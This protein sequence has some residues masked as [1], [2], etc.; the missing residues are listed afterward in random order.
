MK[1]GVIQLDDSVECWAVFVE[2]P[3]GMQIFAKF[4]GIELVPGGAK[5]NA[6]AEAHEYAEGMRKCDG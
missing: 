1:I 3:R 5:V 6:E 2:K 4:Y